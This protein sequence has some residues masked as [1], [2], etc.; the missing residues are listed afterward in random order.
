MSAAATM[1]L[2]NGRIWC[3][4]DLPRA[5]AVAIAG[6]KVLATGANAEIEAMANS[7]TTRIDL[8]GR[9]AMPGIY[10][11]HLHLMSYGLAMGE[12]DLR[13]SVIGTLDELL[14][15]LR[16][17]AAKTPK[18]EWIRGRGYNHFKL[19]V[20]R[21][22]HRDELDA[23]CPDHPVYIV[24]TDGHSGV[25]NSRALALA[26]I[27]DGMP[28]PEG[29]LIENQNGRLT[30]LLAETGR[31]PLTAVMPPYTADQIAEG[32][33]RG[34]EDLLSRGITSV[35][36]AAIG[37]VSGWDD[38]VAFRRLHEEKRLPVRIYGCIMGD[39]TKSILPRVM[40]EGFTT[41]K[42]D[43]WFRCGPVKIFTDGSAGSKTAAMTKPYMGDPENYGL[44]CIPDQEEL[45]ALAMTAHE[46]GYQLG[47]HAIGDAAIEEILNS[48]EK[49]QQRHPAPDRRH[50][51]EHCGWLRPDQMDRMERLGVLPVAQASF[52]YWFGD[53][54]LTVLE[55][56]RIAASHPFRDWIDRG[57]NPSA[58]T[59]CPVTEV[60]PMAVIYNM[61]TRKTNTGVVIGPEQAV[62]I[63]EALH[64]YTAGSAYASHEEEV[65]GRLVPG[66]L[67]DIAVFD[68]DL[69]DC[70]PEAILSARCEMTV[71]DGRVVHGGAS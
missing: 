40:E 2:T 62:T 52:L 11:A 15:A 47:V 69:T 56:A 65:K 37:L 34:G 35:M 3:G 49:A 20:E 54:Y 57:F 8:A 48:I 22:P 55:E 71:V 64:A 30:G 29:G 43:E 14:A 26:G 1:I 10:D 23:A 36:D 38:M 39:K 6:G 53:N 28:S 50:R 58:S 59:D 66:Q 21:H 16:D 25:A 17:R 31:E 33:V 61:V 42:G 32:I 46:A 18:G 63:D 4:K 12:V 27:T 51:I 44:L 13:P 60:D 5:E 19:D 24:R 45:D 7:D 41:G 9:F 67:A 68:T 70:A